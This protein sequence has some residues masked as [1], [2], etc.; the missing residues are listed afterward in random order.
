MGRHHGTLNAQAKYHCTL[1]AGFAE[2]CDNLPMTNVIR[3]NFGR[4]AD[5]PPDTI[6]EFSPLQVYGTAVGHFVALIRAESGDEGLTLQIIVGQEGGEGAESVA[7][8]P[9]NAEGEA[10]AEATAFSILRS[11]EIVK[12]A[13]VGVG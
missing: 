3:P 8:F 1:A 2:V 12:E 5:A 6:A 11:L 9:D 10:D 13:M 7:I 4:P